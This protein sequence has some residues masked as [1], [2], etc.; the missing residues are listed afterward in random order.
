M[1]WPVTL[2]LLTALAGCGE[3]ETAIPPTLT[4]DPLAGRAVTE[5]V[6]CGVCHEI[7]GVTGARGVVGPSLAGFARRSYLA[8]SLPNEQDVLARWVR[9]APALA[10]NTAMPAMPINEREAMDVAAYLSTLR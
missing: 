9:N 6:G 1:R 10:P 5:R 3:A 7:P 8:G 2:L 4:G